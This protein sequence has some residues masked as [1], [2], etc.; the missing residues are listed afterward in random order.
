MKLVRGAYLH[1]DPRHL[2][3]NT[4]EDTDYAYNDAI[5]LLVTGSPAPKPIR[6]SFYHEPMARLLPEGIGKADLVVAS[7]NRESIELALG[8]RHQELA[9]DLKR[10]EWASRLARESDD[11]HDPDDF[12]PDIGVGELTCAQLMGMAD[13]LSL[14][15]LS[16]SD[17]QD[18]KVYKYAVWGTTQECVKYLVRRAEEN[19]DAV[20]RTSENMA[21]CMKEIRRRM[22]FAGV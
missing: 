18:I 21:A 12:I 17:G 7:H 1:T 16:K 4:K 10:R 22:G 19:R 11:F 8:L 15:I 3:H 6:A 13:E 2:I 14:D 20:S 5:R 9:L